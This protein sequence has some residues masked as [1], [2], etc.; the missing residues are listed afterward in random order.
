MTTDL[1][2]KINLRA[3]MIE[4]L[5]IKS[6]RDYGKNSLWIK[7]P[8]FKANVSLQVSYLLKNM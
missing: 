2:H 6:T 3:M 1:H 7:N 8:L 5:T 4:S